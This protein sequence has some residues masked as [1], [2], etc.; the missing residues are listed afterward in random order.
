[1][2]WVTNSSCNSF[3]LSTL[4][5]A[6][7]V[8]FSS[9]LSC[10]P[11]GFPNKKWMLLCHV[12]WPNLEPARGCEDGGGGCEKTLSSCILSCAPG[13]S[14]PRCCSSY[15]PRIES[16]SICP[17]ILEYAPRVSLGHRSIRS[18]PLGEKNPNHSSSFRHLVQRW[19][20]AGALESPGKHIRQ[21]TE[22]LPPSKMQE[23]ISVLW[24]WWS[25]GVGFTDLCGCWQG[26]CEPSD[27]SRFGFFDLDQ[28]MHLTWCE[29]YFLH[30]WR[31]SDSIVC[32]LPAWSDYQG[33]L[34]GEILKGEC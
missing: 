12:T 18:L 1:M 29:F 15:Y 30:G 19:R 17:W 14:S 5:S 32:W 31:V 11:G 33:L 2:L 4:F 10:I 28:N 21:E 25:I 27:G 16:F 3:L 6:A 13:Q 26:S 7:S 20:E 22:K 8:C 9:L 34:K 24:T 23:G